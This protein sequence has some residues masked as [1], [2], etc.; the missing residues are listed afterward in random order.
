MTL[1]ITVLLAFSVFMLLIAENIPATSETVPLIGIYLTAVMSLTSMSIILTVLVLQLHHSGQFAPAMPKKLYT[2]CTVTIANLF[3]MNEIVRRFEADRFA[4]SSKSTANHRAKKP[5]DYSKE[6][7]ESALIECQ[8]NFNQINYDLGSSLKKQKPRGLLCLPCLCCCLKSSDTSPE[9]GKQ[10]KKTQIITDRTLNSEIK[11][12]KSRKGTITSLVNNDQAKNHVKLI[13]HE[14]QINYDILADEHDL[15][16]TQTSRPNKYIKKHKENTNVLVNSSLF[17]EK[18]ETNQ[19]FNPLQLESLKT[20]LAS[21]RS[22]G[23]NRH[24]FNLSHLVEGNSVRQNPRLT[25]RP[26]QM[27]PAEMTIIYPDQVCYKCITK[28]GHFSNQSQNPDQDKDHLVKSQKNHSHSPVSLRNAKHININHVDNSGHRR[29]SQKQTQGKRNSSVESQGRIIVI[30][31]RQDLI[32]E[33]LMLQKEW[34]LLALIFDRV[35]FWVFTVLIGASSVF[36]L[37]VVPLMKDGTIA[38]PKK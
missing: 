4:T 8:H 1:G 24:H 12:I 13:Q 34:K 10:A 25:Q 18:E 29:L 35:L 9:S 21:T 26:Q 36:L 11:F 31:T 33:N 15:V 37:C 16:A 20:R 38:I 22:P 2:F 27:Q 28:K 6:D 5:K 14:N 17:K 32:D 3:C 7:L 19:F 30:K 23:A